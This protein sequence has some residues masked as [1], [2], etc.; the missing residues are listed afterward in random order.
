MPQRQRLRREGAVRVAVDVDAREAERVE[1][2]DHVVDGGARAVGVAAAPETGA[3]APDREP[4]GPQRDGRERGVRE[5]LERRAVDQL[6]LARAALVDEQERSRAAR[7]PE[8]REV[9][10]GRADGR[11]A[12][13]RP[14]WR[15]ACA[16]P[17]R[18]SPGSAGTRCAWCRRT[19]RCATAG[20]TIV[21]QRAVGESGQGVSV[22]AACAGA[23]SRRREHRRQREPA[24]LTAGCCRAGASAARRAWSSAVSSASIS[25]GRVRDGRM[26]SST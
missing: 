6:R 16:G 15:A 14:R 12:R 22:T 19:D 21:P 11:V 18:R 13:A 3:A 25:T 20:T 9:V 7:G 8:H 26:T 4:V 23:A 17:G 5:V 24:A 2:V 10:A 1:H